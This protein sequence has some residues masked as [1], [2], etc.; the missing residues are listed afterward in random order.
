MPEIFFDNIPVILQQRA[1][2]VVWRYETRAG[3]N[4]PTKVPYNAQTGRLAKSDT[5]ATWCTFEQACEVV[6]VSNPRSR[7]EGLC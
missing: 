6:R 2:W 1:Q 5:P 4:K 7:K 3:Q